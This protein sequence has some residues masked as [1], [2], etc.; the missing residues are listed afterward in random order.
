M[1]VPKHAELTLCCRHVGVDI[2]TFGQYLQPTPKHLEVTEF[3][4]PEKFEY[5]RKYGE[6]VI[7][8]RYDMPGVTVLPQYM[9]TVT[10]CPAA[11]CWCIAQQWRRGGMQ[12]VVLHPCQTSEA[13]KIGLLVKP[14]GICSAR[15]TMPLTEQIHV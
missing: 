10:A 15:L 3:V 2:L 1:A 12:G 11:G 14:R 8:F 7:G 5:W 6:D 9:H 13:S 4:T